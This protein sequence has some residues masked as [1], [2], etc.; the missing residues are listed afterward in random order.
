MY[1]EITPYPGETVGTLGA[2][3]QAQREAVRTALATAK[4]A[5]PAAASAAKA[6]RTRLLLEGAIILTLLKLSAPNILN[7]I[8]ISVIVTADAFFVGWLGAA[9]LAG[10][11][12]VFPLKM[13]MQ[14][15]AA[16]G[17]GGAVAS[18]IARALGAGQRD[19]ANALAVHALAI[20]VGMAALF[21]MVFLTW[22][23]GIYAAL[24]GRDE[25]LDIALTYSHIIFAGAIT[26]WLFNTL[27]SIVRGTGNMAFPAAAIAGCAAAD[28]LLSPA[29]LFGWGPFPRLGIAGAGIGFVAA[30][31]LGSLVLGGYLLSARSLV[32]PALSDHAFDA[33]LFGEILRVGAPGAVNV[34]VTNVSV[35][36]MT[37]LA[38]PL[39]AAA[40]AGYGV[41]A[42]IEYVLI[43]LI[44]GLGTALVTMVATNAGAGQRQRAE[45]ISWTGAFVVMAI[46]GA[47]G[48]AVAVL[49][50]LWMG[51]FTTDPEVIAAGSSYLRL[52][53]PV[54]GFYGLGAALYFGSQGFGRLLWPVAANVVRLLVAVGGGW[55]V[56]HWYGGG[57]EALFAAIAAGFLIYCAMIVGAIKAGAWDERQ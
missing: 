52:V 42:R 23:A 17:M 7:L 19:R 2:R 5:A 57:M 1:Q 49:P 44:F 45:K 53:G 48:L 56:T 15:M 32:K 8:A 38:A 27:A 30:F 18:A 40:L 46:T 35:A 51:T 41:A 37:G 13:L 55:L 39:G 28:L 16:S 9:A 33:S 54:Y 36:L 24:G 22:G 34:I 10:V 3:A 29:L 14:H 43:P 20:A 50:G 25:T 26:S 6:T 4:E 11:S 31:A 12:L 47:I 21:S